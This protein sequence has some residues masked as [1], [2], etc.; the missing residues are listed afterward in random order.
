MKR[1]ILIHVGIA[2]L[3]LILVGLGLVF[4]Q[5]VVGEER[6]KIEKLREEA[7]L[8][9][10]QTRRVEGRD[11]LILLEEEERFVYERLLQVNDVVSFL[12]SF[13]RK[14]NPHGAEVSVVSVS[15]KQENRIAI[16][17]SISGS[18]DAVMRTLGSIEYEQYASTIETISLET[19][20]GEGW[21]LTGTY[22]IL[23]TTP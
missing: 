18:F 10:E 16:A 12:E 11:S 23:S 7:A 6:V 2:T 19:T 21:T 20:S 9:K 1:T 8:L 22:T 4:W 5:H 3:T 15:E 13:E 14:G 17:F